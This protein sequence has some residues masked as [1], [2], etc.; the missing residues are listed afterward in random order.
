M[1]EKHKVTFL[2]MYGVPH[3]SVLGPPAFVC[4]HSHILNRLQSWNFYCYADDTYL[5]VP[6]KAYDP[7]KITK[8]ALETCMLHHFIFQ[9]LCNY[10]MSGL[11]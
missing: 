8:L 4:L 2:L 6:L 7:S 3:S 11:S 5:N 1:S 9:N 10:Y